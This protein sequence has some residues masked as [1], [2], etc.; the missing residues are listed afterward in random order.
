MYA[1]AVVES[2]DVR[3]IF[4]NP[5]ASL[6]PPPDRMRSG[7]HK[8]PRARAAHHSQAK[9][10]TW[11]TCPAAA[12]SGI[13]AI[14]ATDSLRNGRAAPGKT[15]RGSPGGVLAEPRGGDG[16]SLL[17]VSEPA[18]QLW[19]RS[20]CLPVSA[21]TW[22]PARPM[23]WSARA[24]PA[25][26]QS[27]APSPVWR[28]HRQ[29]RS[30]FDGQEIRGLPERNRC[31]HLR[32]DIAMMFQDPVGSLSPAPDHRQPDHRALQDSTA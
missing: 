12:S 23:P 16:M 5:E 6:Y 4:H 29:D 13:A 28:R 20:T 27:S 25:R 14:K 30:R 22:P 21:S 19:A 24:G 7:S 31:A 10:P 17:S 3:E 32:K 9:C 18:N 2:G 26:R 1:G 15:G 11:R 8:D